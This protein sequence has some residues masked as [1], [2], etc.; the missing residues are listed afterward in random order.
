MFGWHYQPYVPLVPPSGAGAVLHA[1]G[2]SAPKRKPLFGKLNKL[3]AIQKKLFN[4]NKL[5]AE[6]PSSHVC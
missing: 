4:K 2:S 3:T 1:Q 5:K 6:Q